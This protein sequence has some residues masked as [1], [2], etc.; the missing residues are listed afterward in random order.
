MSQFS[1]GEIKSVNV[2]NSGSEYKRLPIVSG[3]LPTP[4][5]VST[6]T[7]EIEDGSLSAVQV[8]YN[9]SNYSKAKAI[10]E[11]NALLE[12]VQDQGRV[13]GLVIKHAGSGYTTA[14][15]VKIV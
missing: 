11:G 10:V 5:Y 3:V 8:T 7:T 13:T 4:T 1:I 14:P 2:I 15:T 6:A 9:G 12:V